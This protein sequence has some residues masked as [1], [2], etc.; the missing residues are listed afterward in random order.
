MFLEAVRL[1]EESEKI[2]AEA[3]LVLNQGEDAATRQ[4]FLE[5]ESFN[6]Q[7]KQELDEIEQAIAM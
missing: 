6:L 2:E 1:S 4:N 3:R 7:R 5:F